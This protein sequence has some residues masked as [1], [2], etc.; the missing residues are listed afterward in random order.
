[1]P[2]EGRS[3]KDCPAEDE[4]RTNLH[5]STRNPGVSEPAPASKPADEAFQAMIDEMVERLEE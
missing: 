5:P 2:A 4:G 3:R 1:M